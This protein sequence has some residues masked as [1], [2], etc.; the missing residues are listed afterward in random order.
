[1]KKKCIEIK[2]VDI[3]GELKE[4]YIH[5]NSNDGNKRGEAIKANLSSGE[6]ERNKKVTVEKI[7][8]VTLKSKS[9]FPCVDDYEDGA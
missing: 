2:N 8:N 5:N 1:M 4:I 3:R 9:T 6:R 7:Q